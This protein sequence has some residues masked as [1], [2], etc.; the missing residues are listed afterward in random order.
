MTAVA[1]AFDT[2]ERD[3]VIQRLEVHRSGFKNGRPWALYEVHANELDGTPIAVTL[4]TFDDLMGVVRVTLEPWTK[5]GAVSHYTAKRAKTAESI[6]ASR[7]M[8]RA[9]VMGEPAPAPAPDSPTILARLA[10]VE[11]ELE[12]LKGRFL[13]LASILEADA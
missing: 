2:S 10:A 7:N 1:Q 13:L 11:A 6:R 3:I 4:R 8:A 5:D 12:A 9:A